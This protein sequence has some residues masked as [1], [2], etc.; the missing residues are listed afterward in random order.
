MAA[1]LCKIN[2]RRPQSSGRDTPLVP[3]ANA[4]VVVQPR[5]H[6]WRT[7]ALGESYLGGTTYEPVQFLDENGDG[8]FWLLPSN[9]ASPPLV[10]QITLDGITEF[11]L[12]PTL[13]ENPGDSEDQ[14]VDIID[15]VLAGIH[16]APPIPPETV[17]ARRFTDD[18]DTPSALIDGKWLRVS[19][20]RIVQVDAPVPPPPAWGDVTGKPPI[21]A[22]ISDLAG[23]PAPPSTGDTVTLDY[24]PTTAAYSWV[25]AP[26]DAAEGTP[27]SQDAWV[28][29]APLSLANA[30]PAV[31]VEQ[32]LAI[33]T[34]SGDSGMGVSFDG[35]EMTVDAGLD[36]RPYEFQVSVEVEATSGQDA[37]GGRLPLQGYLKI[38]G[39]I[40]ESSRGGIYYRGNTGAGYP[41]KWSDAFTG[42]AKL[43][44]GDSVTFHV[45]RV[46]APGAAAST[47]TNWQINAAKSQLKVMSW[48]VTG[49][50]G[51]AGPRGPGGPAGT[52]V[53]PQRVTAEPDST[54]F[55]DLETFV[56]QSETFASYWTM[57][58]ARFGPDDAPL[59][60]W[61]RGRVGSMNPIPAER[62]I[63]VIADTV[64]MIAD[65]PNRIR[66]TQL[67]AT[68][69]LDDGTLG[70]PET[71]DLA[72]AGAS[73]QDPAYPAEPVFSHLL[74]QN[75]SDAR[76]THP[77]NR[78]TLTDGV[79]TW[80]DH[81]PVPAGDYIVRHGAY[82]P[83]IYTA[84]PA[85]R[86]HKLLIACLEAHPGGPEPTEIVFGG[87]SSTED[88]FMAP[89]PF[90]ADDPVTRVEYH[91]GNYNTVDLRYRYTLRMPAA[92]GVGP[93][94]P[95]VLRVQ[96]GSSALHADVLLTPY[97]NPGQGS[98]VF[99]SSE[100]PAG[101]LRTSAS[102]L[103]KKM[104]YQ[105]ADNHWVPETDPLYT[106]SVFQY[107]D[108]AGQVTDATVGP[109]AD[110]RIAAYQA[111]HPRYRRMTRAAFDALAADDQYGLIATIG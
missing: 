107:S 96:S 52:S 39:V 56:Q 81:D 73:G 19:D 87:R 10:W 29:T 53:T 14:S 84:P 108:L 32:T 4:R 79:N 49:G 55:Q 64:V 61:V 109:I 78:I 69:I 27:A 50:V 71:F 101:A 28:A 38:N 102:S 40:D 54:T 23:I 72:A 60:G 62:S 30:N 85:N 99:V 11:F 20:D 51:P 42:K 75:G 46:A 82:V 97:A 21:P 106:P 13:E 36:A 9:E 66:P 58:S 68:P 16:G 35:T 92:L 80:P 17:R 44:G 74:Q 77:R 25:V 43:S 76:I 24:D 111:A 59:H 86:A 91:D 89:D 6:V 47:V 26:S 94:V 98:A 83:N 18:E 63:A 110:A 41:A 70:A 67:T 65:V 22:A 8:S 57:V 12:V 1:R 90:G 7:R 88:A 48:D 2:G 100:I 105:R 33:G 95:Q 3:L 34:A 37:G 93:N 31:D 15:L 5:S 45:V 104:A 103:T